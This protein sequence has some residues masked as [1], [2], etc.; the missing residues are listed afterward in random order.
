MCNRRRRVSI[1][2]FRSISISDKRSFDLDLCLEVDDEFWETDPPFR[3]PPGV[4]CRV[5]FFNLWLRLSEIVT[6]TV[7]TIYAVHNPRALLGRIAKVRTNEVITQLTLA[8]QDWLRSVPD[9]LR[10]SKHIKDEELSNQSAS[11]YT[12]YHLAE[13]LIYRA[14]IPPVQSPSS[15]N[16]PMPHISASFPAL[17]FCINAARSSARIVETQVSRGW[18]NTPVLVAVSQLSA[19]ILTLGVWDT[20]AKQELEFE[21]VKP[22]LAHTIASLMDDI[23]VFM[24]ALELAAPRWENVPILIRTLKGALPKEDPSVQP[25]QPAP[26][27]RHPVEHPPLD[28]SSSHPHLHSFEEPH[29]EHWALPFQS[30]SIRTHPLQTDDPHDDNRY[31]IRPPDD[32]KYEYE[33]GGHQVQPHPVPDVFDKHDGRLPAWEPAVGPTYAENSNYN[34]VHF[35]HP[36][37]QDHSYP[38]F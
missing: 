4:P 18:T 37:L 38:N 22:P 6:F 27:T 24:G 30:S 28:P 12:T 7:R 5:T 11:L 35:D 10:W 17:A 32:A 14:F 16:P 2:R 3:Q 31:N 15:V 26:S 34:R 1:D 21:D 29:P 9:Y 8:L 13:M 23:G 25:K 20:K 19:A 33:A 36:H